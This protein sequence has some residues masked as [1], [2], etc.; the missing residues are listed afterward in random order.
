M[1]RRVGDHAYHTSESDQLR[2]YRDPADVI[3]RGVDGIDDPAARRI[4]ALAEFLAD[5]RIFRTLAIEAI[6]DRL[7]HGLVDVG[8]RRSIRFR[9][10]RK[11]FAERAK[12]DR[13]AH[14]R[15]LEREL[16]V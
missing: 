4:A 12:G 8:D 3:T 9:S 6:A 1:Q 7:L 13:I 14:V 11:R 5:D 2:E 15:E 10:H 16:Q